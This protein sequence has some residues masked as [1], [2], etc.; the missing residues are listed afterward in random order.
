MTVR[1][2]DRKTIFGYEI[3]CWNLSG[4]GNQIRRSLRIPS[5]PQDD[6]GG[7]AGGGRTDDGAPLLPVSARLVEGFQLCRIVQMV[8]PAELDLVDLGAERVSDFLL[9][10]EVHL[11]ARDPR[12]LELR[13]IFQPLAPHLAADGHQAPRQRTAGLAPANHAAGETRPRLE[14][15]RVDPAQLGLQSCKHGLRSPEVRRLVVGGQLPHLAQEFL[16]RR[17]L[18]ASSSRFPSS[19]APPPQPRPSREPWD[20]PSRRPIRL[21]RRKS[22]LAPL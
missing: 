13:E 14:D 21:P 11:R 15:S 17:H 22:P 4:A 5:L 8:G 16:A 19:P 7:D 20:L 2:F 18:H 3:G 10:A 9:E 6:I 12:L 1:S